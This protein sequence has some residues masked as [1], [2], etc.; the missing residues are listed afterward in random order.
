MPPPQRARE[1]LDAEPK[2]KRQ[3]LVPDYMARC[4]TYEA[5]PLVDVLI[6]IK[7]L[8]YGTS[9]YPRATERC[10]AVARRAAAVDAEYLGKARR[11]DVRDCMRRTVEVTE[12]VCCFDFGHCRDPRHRAL[13][14]LSFGPCSFD[15]LSII[16][17]ISF[18]VVL[19]LGF[20]FPM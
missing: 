11:L 17:W 1:A 12:R 2:R 7:T 16:P 20:R 6:D 5:G 10:R 15:L 4:R 3:G 9:T 19:V 18:L 13:C 14:S 8:H